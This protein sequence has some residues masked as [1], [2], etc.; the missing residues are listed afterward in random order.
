M[1][2]F[3]PRFRRILNKGGTSRKRRGWVR[4]RSSDAG[5]PQLQLNFGPKKGL[6]HLVSGTTSPSSTQA[7]LVTAAPMF[8]TQAVDIP[9]PYVVAKDSY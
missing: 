4:T 9:A 6:S 8:T 2:S 7:M 3:P 1:I 5:Q